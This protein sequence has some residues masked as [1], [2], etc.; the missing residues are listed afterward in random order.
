MHAV[1]GDFRCIPKVNGRTGVFRLT[2]I[3][4]RL[5]AG[6]RDGELRTTPRTI[7]GAV[8]NRPHTLR[9]QARTDDA[10]PLAVRG[11]NAMAGARLHRAEPGAPC[12]SDEGRCRADPHCTRDGR[13]RHSYTRDLFRVLQQYLRSFGAADPPRG[14]QPAPDGEDQR[15]ADVV[16][17]SRRTSQMVAYANAVETDRGDV[18]DRGRL[19]QAVARYSSISEISSHINRS[20]RS[21]RPRAAAAA[22]AARAPA[23]A[24]RP[25]APAPAPAP[26]PTGGGSDATSTNTADWACIRQHES[27]GNYGIGQR[28]RVPVRA[29]HLDRADRFALTR[30]GLP[31]GS[32]GRRRPQALLPARLGALD[33]PLRLRAL[34]TDPR[35]AP[36]R[37]GLN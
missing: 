16:R 19:S 18:P 8:H 31:A 30:R 14:E 34:R 28:R 12:A 35:D 20:Q 27:G 22:A 17:P 3:P 33:N 29:R 2:E 26:A 36:A 11:A 4:A 6:R 24:C 15:H 21:S 7:P 1:S 13:G 23:A 37:R 9:Q 10:F 32:A 5:P 25:P